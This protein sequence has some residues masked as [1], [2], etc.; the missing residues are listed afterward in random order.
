M[1][2]PVAAAAAAALTLGLAAPASADSIGLRD[3]ADIN[4][5]V[6]L[7]AVHVVN[8]ERN[9]RIVLNHTNLRRDPRTGAGGAVYI[10]TRAADRGPEFVF[11][12]GYFEGTD[13]QCWRPRASV[14]GGGRSP[15]GGPTG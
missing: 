11:V 3:P 10:D 1:P 7:R 15:S 2:S 6:D 12:G 8:G 13:Y 4:H 9:L 5:G 14:P